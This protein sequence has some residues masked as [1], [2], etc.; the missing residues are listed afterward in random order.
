MKEIILSKLPDL[1]FN[2][3]SSIWSLF[4][5]R[6]Y[7]RGR[8]VLRYKFISSKVLDTSWGVHKYAPSMLIL[9][10]PVKF[11]LHNMGNSPC[12]V[13]DLS[14]VLYKGK[15][16][17]AKMKQIEESVLRGEKTHF[18]NDGNYTFVIPPQNVQSFQCEYAY[19]ISLD[20][21]SPKAFDSIR[22]S[23]DD[24]NNKRRSYILKSTP[25]SWKMGIQTPDTDWIEITQS[26]R[27]KP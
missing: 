23:Y 20:E 6:L 14:L 10:V 12:I 11:E 2:I 27:C 24:S 5:G 8:L 9:D 18:G 4:T 19:K 13:K 22:L 7:N 21:V 16:K 3:L 25:L 26:M 15:L 1:G 17:V